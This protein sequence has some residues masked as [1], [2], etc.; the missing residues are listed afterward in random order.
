MCV[1]MYAFMTTF[2]HRVTDLYMKVP[3]YTSQD[4]ICFVLCCTPN[5]IF[6]VF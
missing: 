3:I 2:S 4:L 1:L 6:I 5:D